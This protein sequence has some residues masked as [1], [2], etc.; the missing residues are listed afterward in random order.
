MKPID[1]I[2]LFLR[3]LNHLVFFIIKASSTTGPLIASSYQKFEVIGNSK[4]TVLGEMGMFAGLEI[5]PCVY[6]LENPCGGMAE[7]EKLFP[8][9][10]S[11]P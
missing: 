4:R 7:P 5:L 2:D 10:A 6:F 1:I 9:P 11:M 8:V 3:L